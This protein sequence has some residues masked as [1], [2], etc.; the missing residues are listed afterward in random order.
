MAKL[1]DKFFNRVIEGNFELG[2][3]ASKVA[4][5]LEK[6]GA[7][8]K[9]L[10]CHPIYVTYARTAQVVG[11]FTCLIFNNDNTP[12][13]A[14]TFL[15]WA[16]ALFTEYPNAS[17]MAS[18]YVGALP[19]SRIKIHPNDPTSAVALEAALEDGSGN[20]YYTLN[21]TELAKGSLTDG[22]NKIN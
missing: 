17:I 16:I 14:E 1:Q 4:D 9:P 15:A 18:G 6:A 7:G 19:I 3:D 10:Y 11:T 8:V 13:T 5:E 22:V 12:F 21:A 2:E 20:N